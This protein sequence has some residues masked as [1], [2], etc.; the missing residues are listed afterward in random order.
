M[1]GWSEDIGECRSEEE[2]P[3]AARDYLAYIADFTG[4][5]IKLIG[6]GPSRDQVIWLDGAESALAA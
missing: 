5:P 2:L 1:P 3:Q 6:V 4:V